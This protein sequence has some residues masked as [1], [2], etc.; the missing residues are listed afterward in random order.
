MILVNSEAVD[1]VDQSAFIKMGIDHPIGQFSLLLLCQQVPSYL[2]VTVQC[3]GDLFVNIDYLIT[4]VDSD[5]HSEGYLTPI[6][7]IT[8]TVNKCN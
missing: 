6:I 1:P 2:T 4:L 5:H 3:D 8:L 7:G